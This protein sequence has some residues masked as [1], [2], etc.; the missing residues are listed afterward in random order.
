M[1]SYYNKAF[2]FRTSDPLSTCFIPQF[3][4]SLVSFWKLS[5]YIEVHIYEHYTLLES[6]L[7]ILFIFYILYN[8]ILK[9]IS[10]QL[11]T[12]KTISSILIIQ[13]T[14]TSALNVICVLLIFFSIVNNEREN[15]EHISICSCVLISRSKMKAFGSHSW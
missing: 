1:H 13:D 11:I 15:F 7:Y 9:W 2:E 8:N 12:C 14:I 6:S 5:A 10:S 4:L 3:L